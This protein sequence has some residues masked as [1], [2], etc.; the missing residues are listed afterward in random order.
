MRDTFYL[1]S[2]TRYFYDNFVLPVGSILKNMKESDYKA[3]L[4]MAYEQ[5]LTKFE[6][7]AGY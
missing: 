5:K 6:K 7:D 1:H 3:K 4:L 2:K